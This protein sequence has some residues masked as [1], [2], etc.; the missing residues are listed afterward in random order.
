MI[1]PELK[2]FIALF[3]DPIPIASANQNKFGFVK[4]PMTATWVR[5]AI[6]LK[7]LDFWNDDGSPVVDSNKLYGRE[8][9]MTAK[10]RDIC[11]LPPLVKDL[12]KKFTKERTL[13]E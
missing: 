1:D 3:E 2:T 10:G 6:E 5:Q 11:G 12:P 13:F 4:H 7:L 8:M 9:L